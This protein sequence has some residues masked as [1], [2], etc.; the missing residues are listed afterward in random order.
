MIAVAS[1]AFAELFLIKS[2]LVRAGLKEFRLAR[3]TLAADVGHRRN[4]RR[5]SPMI[6]VAVVAGRSGQVLLFIKSLGVD[7][8]LV[9]GELIARDA[10]RFHVI[11]PRMTLR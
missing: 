9:I 6:A 10:E 11:R 5:R 8:G 4:A 1:D 3:V 2:R 7:A